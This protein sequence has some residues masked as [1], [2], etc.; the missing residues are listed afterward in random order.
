[1]QQT[2]KLPLG[3]KVIIGFHL[4]SFVIWLFGQS[5]AVVDYDRAAGWGLQDSRARVDPV[6]VEVNRAIGLTDSI[7]MLPLFLLLI[8]R[9]NP[10]SYLQNM[11]QALTTAFSTASSSATLPVTMECV[12]EKN[13]VSPASA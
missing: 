6:I 1:M 8:A 9:R 4:F 2:T 7:V 5:V 11:G 3:L 12:E 13:G 10:W